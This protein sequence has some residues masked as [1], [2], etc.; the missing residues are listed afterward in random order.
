MCSCGVSREQVKTAPTST[1]NELKIM[2]YNIHIGNPPS[3]PGLIDMEAI[4][5]AIKA[6][7]YNDYVAQEFIPTRPSLMESLKEGVLI[8]DI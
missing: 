8:C 6:T 1:S 4:I 3:K 2:S 7:G 5:K